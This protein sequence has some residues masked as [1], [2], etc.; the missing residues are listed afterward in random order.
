MQNKEIYIVKNVSWSAMKRGKKSSTGKRAED[1]I[2]AV[3]IG[4]APSPVFKGEPVSK[5]LI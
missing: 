3:A 5:F 2:S 1:F 4:V